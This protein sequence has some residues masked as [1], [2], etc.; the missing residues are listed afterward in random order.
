MEGMLLYTL[1][2]TRVH[3]TYPFAYPI[4]CAREGMRVRGMEHPDKKMNNNILQ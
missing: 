1:H 2:N 4:P 3:T